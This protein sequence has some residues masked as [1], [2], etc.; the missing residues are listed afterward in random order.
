MWEGDRTQN[1]KVQ[2]KRGD[3][4]QITTFKVIN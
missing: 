1:Y 3:K 2:T 4:G